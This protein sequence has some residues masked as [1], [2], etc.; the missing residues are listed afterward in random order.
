[1]NIFWQWWMQANAR[2]IFLCS[3]AALI[4]VVAW[5]TWKAL[6]P[7]ENE[8][9][10]PQAAVRDKPSRSALGIIAFLTDELA[11][12]VEPPENVFQSQE[13]AVSAPAQRQTRHTK[14]SEPAK[15]PKPATFSLT[16]KGMFQRTDGKVVALVEDTKS[17]HARFYAD[18]QKVCG[19]KVGDISA[20][21]VAISDPDGAAFTLNIH[22]PKTFEESTHGNN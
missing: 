7:L 14:S 16:Y 19:F 11:S 20:K 18:G 10:A 8:V 5:W 2:R 3:L 13:Q 12:K 17:R 4:L 1:M 6:A 22:V 9:S 21:A 15:P